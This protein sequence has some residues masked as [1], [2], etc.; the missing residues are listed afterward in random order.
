M[1]SDKSPLTLLRCDTAKITLEPLTKK[2]F[3]NCTH[4]LTAT[5]FYDFFDIVSKVALWQYAVTT[6]VF[7]NDAKF[8]DVWH[9][10]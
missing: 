9:V 4:K 8:R 5:V 7:A 6:V 1:H 2:Y 10:S 3:A